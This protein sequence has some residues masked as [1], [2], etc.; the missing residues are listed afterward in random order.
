M[1]DFLSYSIEELEDLLKNLG[2]SAYRAGQI[3][4]WLHRGAYGFDEMTDLPAALRAKLEQNYSINPPVILK[5]LVS[6]LD[7]TT[8]YLIQLSDKQ[9]IEAVIMKYSHGNS[10]C[11]SSQAGCK[12]SCAFCASK[13][14][15]FSRSLTAGEMLSQ[16]IFLEKDYG[17]KISNIVVMGIG[18]PLDNF[19]NTV[20]FLKLVSHPKGINIGQRHISVSTCGIV[21]QIYKLADLK[22]QITLSVSL[23]APFDSIRNQIMPVNRAYNIE[24]LMC[25][26]KSYIKS[27]GRR[28]SFE[29]ILIEGLNDT[30]ECALKLVRLLKGMLCHI[31]LIPV[32]AVAET[33]FNPPGALKINEFASLLQKNGVN[34]TVR[35]TLG[36]DINASCG[37]LRK[38][39]L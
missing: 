23:H 8:K 5:K 15:G 36:K 6:S 25:A 21:P 12:M 26:C 20:K 22:F 16:V 28:I 18:E 4:A 34:C 17:E 38:I 31:N 11:I 39:N 7:E 1:L 14:N 37:Q 35:R 2:E 19:E 24:E 30:K 33:G 27:T 13:E 29:Y 9:C 3:F 32:N 10:V